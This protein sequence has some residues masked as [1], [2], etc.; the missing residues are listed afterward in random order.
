MPEE[1]LPIAEAAVAPDE[2]PPAS[3]P[4]PGSLKDQPIVVKKTST[5]MFPGLAAFLKS[6]NNP[7][8]VSSSGDENEK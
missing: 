1:D 6:I 3:A 4:P 2:E 7:T 5:A 8:P